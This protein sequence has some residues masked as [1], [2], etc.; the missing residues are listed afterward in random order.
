MRKFHNKTL[1]DSFKNATLGLTYVLKYHKHFRTE[2]IIAIFVLILSLILKLKLED[3]LLILIAIFFVLFSEIINTL[4]EEILDLI[5]ENYNEKIK[6]L[7]D[8]SSAIVLISVL[9]SLIVACLI[10]YKNF[11]IIFN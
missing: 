8:I 7:K 9:F 2:I 5:E 10:I 3:V 1:L 4:I 6:I 11:F